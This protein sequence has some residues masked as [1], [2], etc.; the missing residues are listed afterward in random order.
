L[1][2]KSKLAVLLLML[3]GVSGCA[4]Y[5]NRRDSVT[6]GVGNAAAGNSALHVINP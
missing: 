6:L 3:V 2:R 5:M 4:D 1:S